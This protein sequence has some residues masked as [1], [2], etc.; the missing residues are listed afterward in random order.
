VARFPRKHSFAERLEVV[1]RLRPMSSEWR[2]VFPSPAVRGLR[3]A[4]LRLLPRLRLP[5][6]HFQNK[7][8]AIAKL[9]ALHLCRSRGAVNRGPVDKLS[10]RIPREA[11]PDLV[12]S[13]FIHFCKTG[14][15]GTLLLGVNVRPKPAPRLA[16][17][18]Q[19][20]S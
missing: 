5:D 16:A 20:P 1:P 8:G 14:H 10:P 19:P 9:K 15:K 3:P 6:L 17:V 4:S 13:L 12:L 7:D 18:K 2:S 11:V